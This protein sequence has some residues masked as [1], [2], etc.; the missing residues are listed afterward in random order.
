MI[1]PYTKFKSATNF[2]EAQLTEN[3]EDSLLHFFRWSWLQLGCWQDVTIP[4]SGWN[5]GDFSLLTAVT[6]PS[7]EDY[8]VYETPKLDLVY[9]TGVDFNGSNPIEISGVWINDDL[10][11]PDFDTSHPYFIDYPNGRVIFDD[12]LEETDVV[13]MNYSYRTVST[14]MCEDSPMWKEIQYGS[15][16]VDDTHVLDKDQGQWSAIPSIRR[17]QLPA[18]FLEAIPVGSS[19][20]YELGA[21]GQWV[22][23]DFLLHVVAEDRRIR[24]RITDILA[25]EQEHMLWIWDNNDISI[26]DWPLDYRGNRNEDGL[27]YPELINKYKWLKTFIVKT[28]ISDVES[29]NPYLFE[30]SIRL[31]T[32][33]IFGKK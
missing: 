18:V 31:K 21:G 5:G 24:N 26:E 29:R 15:L 11:G 2:N 12:P 14:Q 8:Q 7:Y 13:K 33:T 32:E 28:L 1:D 20:P 17:Q 27:M 22:Y 6:D 10:Y 16:R 4:E 3:I 30:S 25:N 9:E 23:R 19:K